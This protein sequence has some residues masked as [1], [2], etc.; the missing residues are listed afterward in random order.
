MTNR[1]KL[2][3]GA[4]AILLIFFFINQQGQKKYTTK[5]SDLFTGNTEDVYRFTI[6][7]GDEFL[8]LIRMDTTWK[9]VDNDSL[10]VKQRSF[11]NFFD[12]V[13]TTR[14]ESVVSQ[15]PEKWSKFS[16][17]DSTGTILSIYD[18]AGESMGRFVFGSSRSDYSRNYVRINDDPNV[19]QTSSNII[20]QLQT[21]PTYWG[22]KP[23]PP[24]VEADTTSTEE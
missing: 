5:K 8:E 21:R 17:D 4:L 7:K 10:I 14:R 24:V 20:F 16:V 13:L 1:T 18:Y 12:R 3:I 19:Y 23:K 6:T 11:D 15:N 22:E 9:I 2:A